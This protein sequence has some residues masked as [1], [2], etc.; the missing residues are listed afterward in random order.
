[1]CLMPETFACGIFR[2]HTTCHRVLQKEFLLKAHAC[3]SMW[4]MLSL[5]RLTGTQSICWADITGR[6]MYGDCISGFNQKTI[7]K[8]G[9][10]SKITFTV[11]IV[12]LL[13]VTGLGSCKK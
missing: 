6:I 2:W 5:L 3:S 12:L 4:R 13:L 1:M 10:K 11:N 8:N 7:K 9:M